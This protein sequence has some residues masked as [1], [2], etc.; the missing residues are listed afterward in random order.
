MK[1]LVV[2]DHAVVREG[3]RRL[4]A[5]SIGAEI[6]DT[7]S[8]EQAYA[9]FLEQRPEIIVLDLNLP[10][11][12]GLDLLRRFVAEEPRTRVVVFSMHSSGTYVMRAM[13]AGACGFV[14]KSGSVDELLEAVR[15]VM[16]GGRYMQRDL[17][18]ELAGSPVWTKG[19]QHHL[20]AREL[21][22]MRLLAQGQTLTEIAA[23][24]GVSYK[25]VA[26]TCTAIKNKLYI[27]RTGDLIRLAIEMHAGPPH[28]SG[29]PA[30]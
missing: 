15:R 11:M 30:N 16:A 27:Q 28:K 22:I 21:D 19:P 5:S 17:V 10:D 24:L 9:L 13:Q 14:S 25:T 12:S 4:L 23:Q 20:S 8:G 2:D 26:N 3:V 1:I 29:M 7:G 6:N 18:T